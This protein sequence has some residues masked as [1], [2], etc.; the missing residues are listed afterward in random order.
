MRPAPSSG[1]GFWSF[2]LVSDFDIR[3]S[4][5]PP[6]GH[7]LIH[8][9]QTQFRR[10]RRR[11]KGMYGNRL[12]QRVR[13]R[14]RR[15]EPNRSQFPRPG[16]RA[17]GRRISA[18]EWGAA[19]GHAASNKANFH[20]F[21]ARNGGGARK[22]SQS[23]RLGQPRSHLSALKSATRPDPHRLSGGFPIR[24]F[25]LVSGFEI[26]ISCLPRGLARAGP[27][28]IGRAHV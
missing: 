27:M 17:C 12:Q 28:E 24:S 20:C 9:K 18:R 3:I 10:G 23:A 21:R 6:C 13:F 19:R 2:G 16:A 14:A 26:R 1:F 11:G 15:S 5:F 7:V 4:V 22:Q 8:A 25:G